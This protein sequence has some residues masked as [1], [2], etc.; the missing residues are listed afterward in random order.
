M[1]ILSVP[2]FSVRTSARSK[3]KKIMNTELKVDSAGNWRGLMSGEL[4]WGR[5]V[6]W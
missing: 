5:G 4:L 6:R 2:K 3:L 1:K